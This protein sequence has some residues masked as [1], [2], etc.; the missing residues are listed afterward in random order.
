[1]PETPM[2]VM[3]PQDMRPE[4]LRHVLRLGTREDH[5]RLDAKLGACDL[6]T[7]GGMARFLTAHAIGLQ[8]VAPLA[9]RFLQDELDLVMPD[10]QAMVA[11]DLA[12]LGAAA[13]LPALPAL[14][15]DGAAGAA[16]VLI[17]SR[18]G[19]AVL[20]TQGYWS[21]GTPGF[22]RYMEDTSLRTLWQPLVKALRDHAW[23]DAGREAALA[24]ARASFAAFE[25]GLH[26]AETMPAPGAACPS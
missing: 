7:H 16:Y 11:Q 20:R 3:A 4:D 22:S 1:M 23:S 15:D 5:E 17:G 9:A 18:L 19:T 14:T 21:P 25:Q 2:S 10:V 24:T 13:P 12:D 6:A 26:L 8:A